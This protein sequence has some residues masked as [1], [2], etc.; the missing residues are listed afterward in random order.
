MSSTAIALFLLLAGMA[1]TMASR[2]L[3]NGSGG[4][5]DKARWLRV[6]GMGLLI[7]SIVVLVFEVIDLTNDHRDAAVTAD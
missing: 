1:A 3:P 2:R 6:V 5:V 4:G 7:G